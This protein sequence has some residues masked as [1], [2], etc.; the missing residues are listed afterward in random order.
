MTKKGLRDF[1]CRAAVVVADRPSRTSA[2]PGSTWCCATPYP[3]VRPD[4]VL[5][6]LAAV[7]GL[8]ARRGAAADPAGPGT[9]RR[10]T[11]TIGDPL[12]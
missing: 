6:G 3:A 12:A 11:G 8:D 9:A 5:P 2:A 4:D 7:A 1:D 10:T